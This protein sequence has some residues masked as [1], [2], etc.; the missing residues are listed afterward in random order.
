MFMEQLPRFIELATIDLSTVQ[1]SHAGLA[2][3]RSEL[4]AEIF[5]LQRMARAKFPNMAEVHR[6]NADIELLKAHLVE[7]KAFPESAFPAE[8]IADVLGR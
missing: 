2:E 4:E 5:V 8:S 1:P 6:I 7:A 3:Y